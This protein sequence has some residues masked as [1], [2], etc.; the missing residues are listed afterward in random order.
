METLSKLANLAMPQLEGTVNQLVKLRQSEDTFA[1]WRAALRDAMRDIQ[2]I[3]ENDEQWQSQSRAI[4]RDGLEPVRAR[5]S[6]SLRTS[7]VLS[8]V[9][10][11]V[12]T[13]T[14]SGLGAAGGAAAAHG[15]AVGG[16][17]GAAVAKSADIVWGAISALRERRQNKAVLDLIVGLADGNS[18]NS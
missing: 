9:T 10:T 14:F 17:V 16:I 6:A 3:S 13:L 12:R 18:G 7:K 5:A 2:E 15:S 11:G 8:Q 1:E 4:L